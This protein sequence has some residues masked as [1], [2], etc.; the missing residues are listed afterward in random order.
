[1]AVLGSP[2]QC[3]FLCL[4]TSSP[5]WRTEHAATWVCRLNRSLRVYGMDSVLEGDPC[6]LSSWSPQA[7][8]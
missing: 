8:V 4:A 1:M 7:L 5:D 6:S 3:V 2:L